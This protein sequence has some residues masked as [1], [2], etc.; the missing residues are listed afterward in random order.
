MEQLRMIHKLKELPEY[1]LAE[2]FTLRMYQPGDEPAWTEICSYGLLNPEDMAEGWNKCMLAMENLVPE[3]DVYFVCDKTGKA[4][5]TCTAFAVS[6]T[7]SLLHMLG[8]LPEAR[9]HRLATSMT[10][11]GV[12]KMAQEMP[13]GE[14]MMRLKSDDFRVSAVRT[15]LQCG[16]QPVLFDTGMQERW[17][18]ICDKL[19]IHGIEMLD[20]EGNPTGVI[21]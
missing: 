10:A 8:A 4:V 3:R 14:R 13:E 18:A 17:A 11:Y 6:D 20:D 2:G 21:L 1:T 16:F 7:V 19:D 15:Y 5:A 12:R 9:G